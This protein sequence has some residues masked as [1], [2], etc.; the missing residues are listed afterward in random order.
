[1]FC[2]LKA[3]LRALTI[4]KIN[5]VAALSE[6]S[7]ANWENMRDEISEGLMKQAQWSTNQKLH[8]STQ[9]KHVCFHTFL[10]LFFHFYIT[11]DLI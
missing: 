8:N 4:M 7:I 5:W 11:I 1:M 9:K 2:V 6:T 10:L 3:P